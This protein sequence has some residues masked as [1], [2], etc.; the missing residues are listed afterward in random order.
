MKYAVIKTGGKQYRVSEGDE[1][2]IEKLEIEEKKAVTF[3]VVLLVVDG[4]EVLIG[5]PKLAKAKVKGKVVKQYKGDK[6]RVARFRRRKRYSKV[7]GHRQLLTRVK[8]TKI[9]L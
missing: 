3:D 6:I 2:D 9:E 5:E 8:I 7:K 4:E 1:L